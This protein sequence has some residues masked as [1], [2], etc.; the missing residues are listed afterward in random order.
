MLANKI[1]EELPAS[2]NL[3]VHASDMPLQQACASEWEHC[4]T[5][6]VSVWKNTEPKYFDK[7]YQTI[8]IKF[9]YKWQITILYFKC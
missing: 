4:P 8:S 3:V 1:N 7:K 5:G 6:S 9:K 2:K